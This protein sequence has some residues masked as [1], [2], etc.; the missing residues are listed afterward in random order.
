MNFQPIGEVLLCK[1]KSH[2]VKTASGIY[3][4]DI[5]KH[6]THHATILKSTRGEG[7]TFMP[8]GRVVVFAT[9]YVTAAGALAPSAVEVTLDGERFLL[10][11]E[12][13]VL[14]VLLETP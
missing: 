2:E 12:R 8:I 3:I 13:A 6:D 1:L 11:H 10:V 4:P 14:G 7:D 9:N 5:G